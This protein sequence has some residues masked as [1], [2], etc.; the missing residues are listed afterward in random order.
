MKKIQ[1]IIFVVVFLFSGIAQA[2]LIAHYKFDGNATDSVTGNSGTVY[3]DTYYTPGIIGQ[4]AS[5]DGTGDY[6][7]LGDSSDF[8]FGTGDFTVSIWAN[9]YTSPT[10]NKIILGEWT[11]YCGGPGNWGLHTWPDGQ[12]SFAFDNP[13]DP[14]YDH[15]HLFGAKD[16][17]LA[18]WH[19]YTM[20]RNST[21]IAFYIDDV[22]TSI[23]IDTSLPFYIS[24]NL[25]VGWS[26]GNYLS[27]IYQFD[28]EVDDLRIYNHALSGT[29]IQ[30]LY[31]E[32][33]PE[34]ATMLLLGSGLIG[35]AG[36]RR[37]S[38]KK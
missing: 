10:I 8:D 31:G 18:Q 13:D 35:L 32:P 21:E 17:T 12:A 27:T 22:K 16:Y 15:T 36:V 33:I 3:G 37:K 9:I 20:A 6:I 14:T 11:Q 25:F 34:P 30:D 2:N 28:G 4:A 7:D 19:L 5:F 38:K 26:G 24:S 23:Q 1:L 29:E